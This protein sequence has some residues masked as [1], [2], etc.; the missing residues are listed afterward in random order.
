MKPAPGEIDLGMG[1]PI[2]KGFFHRI[3]GFR[4]REQALNFFRPNN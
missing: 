2:G 4:Y 3:D 1:A